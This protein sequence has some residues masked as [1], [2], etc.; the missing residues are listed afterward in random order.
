ML[1][2][3]VELLSGSIYIKNSIYLKEKKQ[4]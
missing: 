2:F 4:K 3:Q 1:V